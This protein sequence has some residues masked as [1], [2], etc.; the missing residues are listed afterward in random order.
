MEIKMSFKK[1]EVKEIVKEYALKELGIDVTQKDIFV[2]DIFGE[3][4]VEISDKKASQ[5]A[6]EKR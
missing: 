2:S 5:V 3:I 4:T 1:D 6:N